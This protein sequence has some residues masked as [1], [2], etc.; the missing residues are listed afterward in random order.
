MSLTKHSH[1]VK[2]VLIPTSTIPRSAQS[3]N[4]SS[5]LSH[6][7]I[8]PSAPVCFSETKAFYP[9]SLNSANSE[10]TVIQQ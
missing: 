1:T 2:R 9:C 6:P 10:M 8:L 5:F 3:Q 4:S 7:P